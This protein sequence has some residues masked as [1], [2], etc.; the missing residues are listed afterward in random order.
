MLINVLIVLALGV[1]TVLLLVQ[2]RRKALLS[3]RPDTTTGQGFAVTLAIAVIILGGFLYASE[4]IGYV[5]FRLVG[6]A[7]L[8]L[9]YAMISMG[10]NNSD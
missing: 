5:S 1:A 4:R 7:L 2:L 6:L 9:L 10:K 3:E 8:L